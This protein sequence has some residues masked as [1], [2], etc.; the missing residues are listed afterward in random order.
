MAI[1]IDLENMDVNARSIL[2]RD[3]ELEFFPNDNNLTHY[4]NIIY[5]E[6]TDKVNFINNSSFDPATAKGVKLNENLDH[7]NKIKHK[8]RDIL[9]KN[10]I[11]E[12]V[13]TRDRNATDT[14]L[15][16]QRTRGESMRIFHCR[17]CAMEFDDEIQLSNHLRMHFFI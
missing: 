4:Y 3:M 13:V 16:M 17:H 7:L 6:N 8:I 14:I 10:S 12:Y 5:P 2:L 9:I 15:V 1:Y 11:D